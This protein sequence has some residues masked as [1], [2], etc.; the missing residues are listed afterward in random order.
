MNAAEGKKPPKIL[1]VDDE[2]VN[3]ELI[4]EL[5]R[6]EGYE[7]RGTFGGREALAYLKS[8]TP[9]LIISDVLMPDMSGYELY[10]CVQ[11]HRTWHAIPFIFLSGLSDRESIRAGKE[12]GVDD[13]LTKPIDHVELLATVRGKLKR[14]ARIRASAQEEVARLK[15]EIVSTL[16]HEFRTPLALIQGISSLLL[17]EGGAIEADDLKE[18]LEG[19][20]RGGD[21]LQ[22]LVEDFLLVA[23]IESGEVEKN[24]ERAKRRAMIG[25]VLRSAIE[26]AE[27]AFQAKG[28]MYTLSLPEGLPAVVM[29][30]RQIQDVIER[31]LDNAVKFSAEG[32]TVHIQTEQ[33]KEGVSVRVMDQGV[34]I[35]SYEIPH[36]FDKFYQAGRADM[37]QQGAGLGLFIARRLTE[38]NGGTLSCESQ[39]GQGATFIL[40]LPI[41]EGKKEV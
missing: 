38:I 8:E 27:P 1:V 4:T 30:E 6:L 15:N 40:F 16:S 31:V 19:I 17:D 11:A 29:N 5:L 21:R 22:S 14:S 41:G 2:E 28:M 13:Y 32:S 10:D 24:Y 3:V 34:G 35:A 23:N 9:D 25:P 37:E 33:G 36:I 39:R 18:F 7:V 12:I 26:T 20:K